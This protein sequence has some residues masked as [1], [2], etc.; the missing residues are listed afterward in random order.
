MLPVLFTLPTPWG[1]QPIYAYGVLLGFS[2]IAGYQIFGQT[3]DA[4]SDPHGDLVPGD[5]REPEQ[6]AVCVD[7]LRPPG[8]RQGEQDGKHGARL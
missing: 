6:D 8:G 5:Q 3:V 7:R 1:S 4:R 2:L